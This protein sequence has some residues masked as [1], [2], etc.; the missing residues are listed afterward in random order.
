MVM[1]TVLVLW[2]VST[3]LASIWL[4]LTRSGRG[5]EATYGTSEEHDIQ[6]HSAYRNYLGHYYRKKKNHMQQQQ[7][8]KHFHKQEKNK[9]KRRKNNFRQGE[10]P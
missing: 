9:P 3:V 2:P 8:I 5:V 10:L 7:K 4:G 6:R 1:S